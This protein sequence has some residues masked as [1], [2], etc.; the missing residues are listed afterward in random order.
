[1]L[2]KKTILALLFAA[3]LPTSTFAQP[4]L[5][6]NVVNASGWTGNKYSDPYGIYSFNA[7]DN[8]LK[9]STVAQSRNLIGVGGGVIVGSDLYIYDTEVEGDMAHGTIYK[10]ETAEY[11]TNTTGMVGSLYQIPT[12][13]T[14][15]SSKNIIY[16]C[17]Y[18]N[19]N[20]GFEFGYIYQPGRA[21]RIKTCNAKER[22]VAMA[23]NDNGIVYAIG[24]SGKLYTVDEESG[25]FTE[26]GQTGVAPSEKIQSACY[27]DGVIY[28]AAQTSD[29]KGILYKVDPT[30][31]SATE[32]GCFPKNEQ[33]S[34]L[35]PYK[36]PAEDGAPG[37]IYDVKGNFEGASLDGTISFSLP[38]TTYAGGELKGELQWTV[39]MDGETLDSGK[40]MPGDEI[41]TK[42]IT[43]QNEFNAIELFSTNSVGNSLVTK[44][45][46]FAG[47]DTPCSIGWGEVK[48]TVDE[49]RKAT[50]T[51][52]AVTK[53]I[54]DGYF[55]PED[56][57]YKVVRM[58]DDVEVA[59]NLKGTTFTEVLPEK[60]GVTSYYYYVT[61]VFMGNEGTYSESNKVVVGSAFEVP[62]EEQFNDGALDYWT[63]I[64]ANNDYMEW[65]LNSGA[66]YSQAGYDNGSDDWLISPAI[67]LTTGRYYKLAFKYWGGLPDYPDDYKGSDFEVGFGKG[68]DYTQFQI[69]GKKQGVVLSEEDAK[70][71]T[72]V[73]KVDEDGNYNFGIHD[74]SPSDA[75]LLYV[76]SFTVAEGGTLQVPAQINDLK[77]VADADG[78]LKVDISF[79]APSETAEGKPLDN[80]QKIEI[81]RDGKTVI[82][83][84]NSP[85]PGA[86]LSF[87]DTQ[88]TGLTDGSHIYSVTSTN[89]KG[90]SLETEASVVVGIEAPGAPSDLTA[91]EETDG[92]HLAWTAPTVDAN[93]NE[94]NPDNLTYTIVAAKY[95][96]QEYNTVATDVK[97][98][99]F[100]DNSFD[101]DGEQTQ[102][103]YEVIANNRAGSSEPVVSNTFIVGKP[104]ELPMTEGFS[105]EYERQ[106]KYLWWID[107]T[108]DLNY[109]LFF[110]FNTGMSSDGD[111]GCTAFMAPDGA[112]CNLR[113]GKINMSGCS[114]PQ[115]S[116]DFYLDSELAASAT[117]SVE[118]SADLSN[119]TEL[120]KLDYSLLE[121]AN[122]QEWR[123]HT[124]DLTPCSK[125][126]YV[127]LRF[128]GELHNDNDA[129]VL[130][131]VNITDGTNGINAVQNGTA[132]RN[133]RHGIYNING[134][135]VGKEFSPITVNHTRGGIFIIDGKKISVK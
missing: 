61:P 47:P 13:L 38:T 46:I 52:P 89:D 135:L 43:L 121:P 94:I 97:G 87:T 7:N 62:F 37:K 2:M 3:L 101:L 92:I 98:T 51:W 100:V 66:V 78:D 40:G 79:T 27:L 85:T 10:A 114:K 42:Q 60:S 1:M 102:V 25:R 113:S 73:V 96:T 64:D 90:E 65:W 63:V 71:F 70:V 120:D 81:K 49:N 15:D 53:G 21:L 41:T 123:T 115:M 58:P 132:K 30:S 118:Y 77:A 11:S 29:N 126:P 5:C 33:F 17:F 54:N 32:I 107:I 59:S 104:Y 99:S 34:C 68:T 117:L 111:N 45:S 133:N 91:K 20:D 110:R 109:M 125:Y 69:L 83:T 35:Y 57:T 93:G 67:H 84:F 86:K 116:Y 75:Y 55:V 23:D 39:T 103:F 19:D 106:S 24:I 80:I 50:V 74:V 76:D 8:S 18:N 26:V 36:A 119:W 72:A 31:G 22:I 4:K 12:A 108:Q 105:P 95:Y 14:W 9:L 48:L 112:Y 28:W 129:I 127:Y 16:G 56:V 122:G 6:G 82:K 88:A 128:H 124:L 130:D 134:Q 44:T 131:N